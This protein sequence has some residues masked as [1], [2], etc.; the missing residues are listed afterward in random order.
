M[1]RN[2]DSMK[3]MIF[4]EYDENTTG[5]ERLSDDEWSDRAPKIITTSFKYASTRELNGSSNW[6]KEVSDDVYNNANNIVMV[7]V[8]YTDGDTFGYTS[9]YWDV[10]T[11][12]D[13]TD[14]D[15]TKKLEELKWAIEHSKYDYF[16]EIKQE[17]SKKSFDILK[18]Y[19]YDGYINWN[20]Y[21]NRLE[22]IDI[23]FLPLLH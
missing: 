12:F 16:N 17:D 2:G 10:V 11:V 22:S 8:K 4:I 14:K 6:S 3:K 23:I 18:T 7:V 21:F 1:Q 13:A 19:G 5:G 15:I 9:G 20:G